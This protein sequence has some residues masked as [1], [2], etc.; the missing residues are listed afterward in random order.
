VALPNRNGRF[1]GPASVR[2]DNTGQNN[3]ATAIVDVRLKEEFLQT[4][5]CPDGQFYDISDEQL[6]IAGFV[7]LEK[8]DGSLNEVGFR[9]LREA[10]DWNGKDFDALQAHTDTPVQVTIAIEE[11]KGKTGPKVKWVNKYGS[12]PKPRTADPTKAKE[13]QSKFGA[14]LRALFGGTPKQSAKPNGKPTPPQARPKTAASAV[15]DCT[16]DDAWAAFMALQP[17]D[18]KKFTTE[19]L[20]QEWQRIYAEMFPEKAEPDMTAADW[21]KF[22]DEGPA[23]VIPF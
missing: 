8:T 21:V 18:P 23:K 19:Y 20:Q 16:A 7:Y 5:E 1:Q 14:K 12:T 2:L 10:F 4:D 9:Q 22:R 15:A 3:L 6:Q 17:K 13:F 11:Y